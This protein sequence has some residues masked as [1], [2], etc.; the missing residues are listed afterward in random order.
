LTYFMGQ[1]SDTQAPKSEAGPLDQGETSPLESPAHLTPDKPRL[2][3]PISSID[4]GLRGE[5]FTLDTIPLQP[6]W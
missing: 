1:E 4:N 5:D 6:G 2:F 3:H